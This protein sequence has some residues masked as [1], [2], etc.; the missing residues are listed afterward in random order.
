MADG[1]RG[2]RVTVMGLGT[3]GGGLGVARYLAE[4]G[5]I[6]TVTDGKRAEELVEPIRALADLPIRYVLGGHHDADFTADGA[7]VVVRNPGVR[8]DSRY[9]ALARR[10]GVAIEM[11]MSL[12]FRA[13]PAPIIGVT[14]TKGKT[15]VSTLCA[16]MLSAGDPRT[17][18]AGNM[19]TSALAQ[20]PGIM[21]DVPVVIEL[22]SWQLEALAEYRLA[23]RIAVLTNISEDH[24]D[25]YDGFADYAATKRTI[26]HHQ[27]L[28]DCLVVNADDEAAWQAVRE[29][30]A[31]VVPFGLTDGGCAG[32]WH[33]GDRIVWRHDGT[34]MAIPFPANPALNGPHQ[35]ANAAAAAAAALLRGAT[36]AAVAHGL[37]SFAGVKNRLEP[38]AEVG[39]VSFVNDTAA[40]APAAAI[41]AL[42]SFGG[43]RIH[44]IAGGADKQTDLALFAQEAARSAQ[45]MYLLDGTATGHLAALLAQTE[46]PIHGPFGSM[47]AA[48]RAAAAAARPGDV[49]LLSPG[50]A[51]FGL[52][53]DEF[54]RGDRFRAA[55]AALADATAAREGE[56]LR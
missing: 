47:D 51:S 23:P 40:T 15:T 52:F 44:L 21:P 11:E 12:F 34:E 3:R 16:A 30:G 37:R 8:R 1:Y 4:A 25:A 17:V 48:V 31:R 14:G 56:S 2:Q 28:G 7:D 20:L 26:G 45:A 36:P 50:C 49:V 9:L 54:D 39:G 35:A 18:L 46:R 6:V 53:R 33:A 19:G 5:A 29:T 13:C 27:G 55:V 42:R 10:S 22:S 43:R 41:A 38:V 24:L 32:A